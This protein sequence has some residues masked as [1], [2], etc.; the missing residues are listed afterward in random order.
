MNKEQREIIRDF[1]SLSHSRVSTHLRSLGLLNNNRTLPRGEGAQI[2]LERWFFDS[3]NSENYTLGVT[4][5]GGVGVNLEIGSFDS[6]SGNPVIFEFDA[7]IHTAPRHHNAVK[8]HHRRSAELPI[9]ESQRLPVIN[10]FQR[11]SLVSR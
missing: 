8:Y 9:C 4:D 7:D 1:I 5:A 6:H 2:N 3:I 10:F 11:F